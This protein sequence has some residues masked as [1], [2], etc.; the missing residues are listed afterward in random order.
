[1]I[2]CL[3]ESGEAKRGFIVMPNKAMPWRQLVGIYCVIALFSL[4]VALGFFF[5]GLTLILPFAGM[6]LIALAIVLY[7]SAWR[8]GIREVIDIADDKVRVEIGRTAPVEKHLFDR[9]WVQVILE[10]SRINWYPSRLLLRS[11]GQ[12]VEVGRFLN[13]QERQG[14]A[15]ELLKAIKN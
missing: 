15:E 2:F 3:G 1:M 8:G 9:A 7:V 5:Q 12:Q 14:L 6:E 13:E 11:H 10:R 4:T